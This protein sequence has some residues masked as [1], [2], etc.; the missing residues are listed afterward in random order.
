MLVPILAPMTIGTAVL[1]LRPPAATSET[2]T[3]VHVEELCTQ[4][5]KRMPIIKP[6]I[7]LDIIDPPK[8]FPENQGIK[9]EIPL[10]SEIFQKQVK[11]RSTTTSRAKTA[12]SKTGLLIC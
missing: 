3:D 10:Q 9:K 11:L 2:M 7:G 4:T 6:T 1:T 12:L 5:V 8:I